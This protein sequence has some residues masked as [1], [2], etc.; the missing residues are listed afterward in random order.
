MADFNELAKNFTAIDCL[1]QKIKREGGTEKHKDLI[2][3]VE[4]AWDA[5]DKSS[6]QGAR[7][8]EIGLEKAVAGQVLRRKEAR[9]LTAQAQARVAE[10]FEAN[11]DVNPKEVMLSLLS[12]RRDGVVKGTSVELDARGIEA[13]A[14]AIMSRFLEQHRDRVF[15]SDQNFD[16]VT[17][18]VF[19]ESASARGK[20]IAQGVTDT[21]EFLR[22][23]A[24]RYGIHIDKLDRF[25]P[26]THDHL[27]VRGDASVQA[28][29][30]WVEF[31]KAGLDRS[32]M[33][34]W[35]SGE[36]MT[37]NEVDEF[38][39]NLWQRVADNEL[40]EVEVGT[41]F[42]K[43]N[44]AR[45]V[46]AERILHFKDAASWTAYQQRYGKWGGNLFDNLGGYV[47]ALSRDIAMVK[48]FGLN[49]NA[50]VNHAFRLAQARARK[51]GTE[52][53]A[54]PESFMNLYAEL[55]GDA[56][57]PQ[58]NA[59]ATS[60]AL[61]RNLAISAQMGSSWF[62]ALTDIAFASTAAK[63]SGLSAT[64]TVGGMLKEFV[65]TPAKGNR[66]LLLSTGYV[67]DVW[68]TRAGAEM[69]YLGEVSGPNWSRWA[70][71]RVLR[72]SFLQP[73]TE[74]GRVSFAHELI[75]HLMT[76]RNRS[77]NG[78]DGRMR[79]S[80]ERYG[81]TSDDWDIWRSAKPWRADNGASYIRPRD[82][83]ASASKETEQQ[84]RAAAGKIQAM[85]LAEQEIAIP[86]PGARERA[87][88][89][90]GSKPGTFWG[91]TVRTGTLLKT[92]PVTA[93]SLIVHRLFMDK[94][95]T[96]PQ[97]AGLIPMFVIGST[98]VAGMGMQASDMLKGR[99]PRPMDDPRFWLD[100]LIRGG[101]LGI[102]GDMM[103]QNANRGS[104][105]VFE[106]IGGPVLPRLINLGAELPKLFDSEADFRERELVNFASRFVPGESL[107]FSALALERLVT[108][109]VIEMVDPK[110]HDY[111]RNRRKY[112]RERGGEYWAPP[113][114][115]LFDSLEELMR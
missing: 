35:K 43:R 23:E 72:V 15:G 96:V 46:Q 112:A 70:A 77:W 40:N 59:L 74:A 16:D 111:F 61:V 29:R 114:D 45:R 9:A 64:R 4:D 52:M 1:A 26:Q 89:K 87:L 100:A 42:S 56:H 75:S 8:L 67:S 38:L 86:H 110:A 51:R 27:K 63:M 69:R 7:E 83:I 68:S 99:D 57:I 30:E 115:N 48:T 97:K 98:L 106:A 60:G 95:L 88:L 18:A 82:V 65:A 79:A 58:S 2:K 109:N 54:I 108:D 84:A 41:G 28:K 11:P 71:D 103:Y 39:N 21:L 91:E 66:E 49:P 31:V 80:L 44:Y 81:V 90:F 92:F 24:G 20:L 34:S 13:Q 25:L 107:W 5:L 113:G 19:R 3:L 73:W 12:L 22:K 94:L 14:H 10:R 102:A 62:M 85:I 55:S 37:D 78:L 36:T 105:G 33:K 104:T 32:R 47:S 6:V 50:G 93:M 53:N 101:S 17:R 76:V